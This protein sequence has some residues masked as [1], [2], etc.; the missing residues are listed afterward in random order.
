MADAIRFFAATDVGKV[1]DH[2]E[3]NFLVDKKL[4]LFMVADGMGGHAAGEVASAI[5]VRT[6]HEE[7]KREK[8]LLDD[9][10]LG[11][12]GAAKVTPKDIVGLLEHAV[13]RA[14][15]KIHEEAMGDA[16]KRGMGTTLSALLVLGPK[17]FIAHVG[18]S[19][20]YRMRG[21]RV[22]QVTE[23]HTVFNELIKRGK[24]SKEQI[25][26]VAQKNAPSAAP[27]ASTS[28]SRSTKFA[29]ELPGDR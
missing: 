22:Q 23:D 20:I 5:A 26:K 28:G 9:Y 3:D 12:T 21:G 19:R 17:G 18:D 27:S 10:L 6:V 2:N 25:E 11:A 7:L 13:Q 29:A 1:R 4:S 14:C 15:S 8:E 24:L 16:A